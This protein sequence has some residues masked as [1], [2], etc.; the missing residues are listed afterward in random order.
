MALN[1]LL[2]MGNLE[3]NRLVDNEGAARVWT[4]LG[5]LGEESRWGRRAAAIDPEGLLRATHAC[6]SR[7]VIPGDAEWPAGIRDLG[8]VRMKSEGGPPFG[9]WVRGSLEVGDLPLAVAMVGARAATTYGSH[10]ATEMAADVASRGGT[11]VSGLAYGIDAAAHRGALLATGPTI[12][13]LAG[14]VDR[15]YPASH[16]DLY[17]A[18]L[19]GGCVIAEA[20]PGAHPT[21]AAFLARNRLIAALAQGVVVVE[22]AAR[23]GAKNTAAWAN[24]LGRTVMAVPGPVTSA[25]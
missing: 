8:N 10:V 15:P 21:K 4:G 24:E 19:R 12:A 7:F 17:Q 1:A 5:R 6:A 18:V 25:L 16:H 20:P 3:L 23:S 2:P 9:L 13:V 14:G 22:A 11:V